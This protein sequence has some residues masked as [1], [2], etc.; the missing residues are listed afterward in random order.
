MHDE[1]SGVSIIC[2]VSVY[3][4]WPLTGAMS[5]NNSI[6]AEMA[7]LSTLP[8]QNFESCEPKIHPANICALCLRQTQVIFLLQ[9]RWEVTIAIP[10][11]ARRTTTPKPMFSSDMPPATPTAKRSAVSVGARFV[12]TIFTP[13]DRIV[14]IL[15]FSELA[16]YLQAPFLRPSKM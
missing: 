12:N 14:T 10:Q 11:P 13:S 16:R 1:S 7:G 2:L 3:L 6:P 5:S 9:Q 8:R 15:T 4:F